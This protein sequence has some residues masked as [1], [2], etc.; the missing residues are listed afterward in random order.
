MKMLLSYVH[1]GYMWLD[2]LVSIDIDLIV[3]NTCVPSKGLDLAIEFFD[4]NK[5]KSLAESMKD[6]FHTFQGQRGMDAAS[7]SDPMVIFETKSL[8][9]KLL[10]KCRKDQ[11][12]SM[13]IAAAKQCVE[14]V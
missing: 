14:G 3:H 11:V 4:K 6:K 8:A 2:K 10:R 9:F 7:I 12:L 13:I 5:E 1:R